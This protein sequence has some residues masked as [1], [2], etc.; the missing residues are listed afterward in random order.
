MGFE[1]DGTISRAAV[2]V[3]SFP[4]LQLQ[5]SAIARRPPLFRMYQDSS[6]FGKSQLYWMP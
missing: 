1:A 5:E 3:L 2:A 6:R 4:D